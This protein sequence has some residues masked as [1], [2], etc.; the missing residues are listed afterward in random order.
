MRNPVGDDV[1]TTIILLQVASSE[2]YDF[3]RYTIVRML[4]YCATESW[5]LLYIL[6][7]PVATTCEKQ[8][9][10]KNIKNNVHHLIKKVGLL[11]FFKIQFYNA[12]YKIQIL[13]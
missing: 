10:F 4:Y 12:F 13:E 1:K 2:V 11:H 7:C 6:F 3:S 5:E 8:V 9:W